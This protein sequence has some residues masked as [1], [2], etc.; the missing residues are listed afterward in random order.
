MI[1]TLAYDNELLEDFDSYDDAYNAK[2]A[3]IAEDDDVDPADYSIIERYESE[4][5][6]YWANK[7]CDLCR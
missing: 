7:R 5:A 4:E 6:E 2:L 3:A 1:Y